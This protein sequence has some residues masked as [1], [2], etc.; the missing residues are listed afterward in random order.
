MALSSH[1]PEHVRTYIRE[2]VETGAFPSEEAV[3]TDAVEHQMHEYRWE[4]DEDLLE[5]IAEAAR[6][7]VISVDDPA[8]YLDRLAAE[9]REL[10]RQ[11]HQVSDDVK[12]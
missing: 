1:L 2:Q 11:G 7:D 4:A 5:A 12:Y 9:A 8:A 10:V 3:I 6:G